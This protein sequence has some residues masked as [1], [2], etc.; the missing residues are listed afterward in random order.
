MVRTI[1]DLP[2]ETWGRADDNMPQDYLQGVLAQIKAIQPAW[3]EPTTNA[4][5]DG[6][7]K[8]HA[9]ETRWQARKMPRN[10]QPPFDAPLVEW[11]HEY[12]FRNRNPFW[13]EN[14]YRYADNGNLIHAK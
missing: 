14:E 9:I 5:L 4:E 6:S 1:D 13:F 12:H 10:G 8:L 2:Q 3:R 7:D 11:F